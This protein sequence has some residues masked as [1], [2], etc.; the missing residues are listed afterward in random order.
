M[1]QSFLLA[2]PDAAHLASQGWEF[3]EIKRFHAPE[4]RQG[5]AADEDH[6]YVISNHNLGKYRKTSGELVRT[7]SCSKG[8]P[9]IH[10]NAGVVYEKRLY[11]AHSNFPG[12]PNA[13]SVEIWDPENLEHTE[14]VS[15]GRTDGSLTWFDRRK[16]R[17]IACFVYYGERYGLPGKGPEWTRLAE[18]DDDWR[19]T[20]R[21]WTFPQDALIHL[22]SRGFS[23]SGGAIGP[24]DYLFVTGHDEKELLVLAFPNGGAE[25]QWVATVP[26]SGEG[27]A[28]S[29]DPVEPGVMHVIVKRDRLVVTGRIERRK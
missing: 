1:I 22:G 21:G 24:G 26:M 4:A 15:F 14:S 2:D 27:Q 8:E 18:Y 23:V 28:F 29:W 3:T 13:S 17:W 7:W 6:L 10:L 11:L 19:P 12:I 9:F 20:G 16:G 5:V 25:L